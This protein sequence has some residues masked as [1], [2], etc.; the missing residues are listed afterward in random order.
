MFTGKGI[1]R[2]VSMIDWHLP[3][4]NTITIEKERRID[5]STDDNTRDDYHPATDVL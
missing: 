2:T 3:A 4:L 5:K 1:K